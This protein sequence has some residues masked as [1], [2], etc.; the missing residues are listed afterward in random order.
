MEIWNPTWN[1]RGPR[2]LLMAYAYE[3]LA[4][5]IGAQNPQERI[6]SML[7]YFE[8]VHPGVKENFEL[9]FSWVLHASA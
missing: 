4:R 6:T 8:Q 7:N 5:Q 1:Q 2:G 3:D 9:G